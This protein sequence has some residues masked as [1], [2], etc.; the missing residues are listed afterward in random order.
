V[1]VLDA[2]AVLAYLHR[3]LGADVVRRASNGALLSTVN[4]SE[5]LAKIVE[6]GGSVTAAARD[7]RAIGVSLQPFDEDQALIAAELRRITSA[8]GLSFGDRACLALATV[9]QAEV[10]TADRIWKALPLA[11]PVTLVR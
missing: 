2:S 3:E 11:V 7:I 10:L 9:R 6:H 5:V 1:I 8:A 4:F